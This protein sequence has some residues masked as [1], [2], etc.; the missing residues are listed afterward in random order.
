MGW[1]LFIGGGRG[2]RGNIVGGNARRGGRIG[3]GADQ[4]NNRPAPAVDQYEAVLPP[5]KVHSGAV[6]PLSRPPN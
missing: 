1:C 4:K 3:H 5:S 6:V 2:T